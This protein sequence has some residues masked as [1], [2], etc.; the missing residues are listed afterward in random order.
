[1]KIWGVAMVRNEA[2]IIETFVRHNL[3]R[4]DGLAIVDHRSA[5]DT[6]NILAA[7]AREGLP[8]M[9]LAN[10]AVAYAQKEIM[11]SALRQVLTATPADFVFPLDADEFIKTP[12][13]ARMERALAAMPADAHGLMN[14]PTYVPD[15]DLPW[16]GIVACARQA[17]RLLEERHR[18]GKVVVARHFAASPRALLAGGNHAVLPWFGAE[19]GDLAPHHVFDPNELALAHLPHRN[20]QQFVVKITVNRL[21]RIAAGRDL[22]EQKPRLA[23]YNRICTGIPIDATYLRA[24]TVNFGMPTGEWIDPAAAILVDDPF[25]ADITLRHT[26][27]D[28]T[29]ALPLV[30]DAVEQL[31]LREAVARPALSSPGP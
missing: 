25:L 27:A 3:T 20:A 6:V 8:L 26:A 19:A 1:M 16:E 17:R 24:M 10:N 9:L 12:S 30:I 7:L 18:H 15:F 21:A 11:T 5:D 22:T 4:L 13:R 2:D 31:A 23:A 28:P 29:S 14:W